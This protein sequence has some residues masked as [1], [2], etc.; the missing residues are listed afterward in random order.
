M[1]LFDD[2]PPSLLVQVQQDT[3]CTNTGTTDNIFL[4]SEHIK[5]S[6]LLQVQVTKETTCTNTGTIDNIYINGSPPVNII[7]ASSIDLHLHH[8]QPPI[9]AI[10]EQ[11]QE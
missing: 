7:P 1:N 3:T 9:E 4:R 10:N 11:Q 8:S 5:A 2:D 6:P